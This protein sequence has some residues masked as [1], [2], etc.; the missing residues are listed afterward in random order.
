MSADIERYAEVLSFSPIGCLLVE[1]GVIRK[2]NSEAI[3]TMGIPGDRLVGVPLAE[4]L[5]PEYEQACLEMLERASAGVEP[6]TKSEAV[7]LARGLAPME[8]SWPGAWTAT[9]WW[10]ASGRWPTSTTTRPRPEA[11]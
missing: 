6:G 2:A 3:E 11:P 10:S 8:A 7:R 1:R 4:L 5:V 9:W